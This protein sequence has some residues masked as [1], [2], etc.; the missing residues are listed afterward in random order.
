[1]PSS[2][3]SSTILQSF[4][5]YQVEGVCNFREIGGYKVSSDSSLDELGPLSMIV[6]K[7][8]IFRSAELTYITPAGA[9]KLKELGIK[10]VFD[11][12]ADVEIRQYKA[13]PVD[14][15]GVGID[16]ERI[17]VAEDWPSDEE[18]FAKR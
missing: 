12:R 3:T 18:D 13:P 15:K 9:E 4:P 6:Q 17:G 10:K 7:K 8:R 2:D 16:V 5:F 1:M 14:L 11:L